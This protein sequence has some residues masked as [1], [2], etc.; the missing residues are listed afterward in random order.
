[1]PQ[2]RVYN[3]EKA[4]NYLLVNKKSCNFAVLFELGTRVSGF[5]IV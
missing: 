3:S 2:C 5:A 4:S 1:M